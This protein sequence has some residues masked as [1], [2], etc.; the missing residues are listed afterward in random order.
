MPCKH[1][2]DMG[3]ILRYLLT[4]V[5]LSISH[6]G[7]TIQK[8][9]KSKLLQEIQRR[10]APNPPTN[11]DMVCSFSTCCSNLYLPLLASHI[12]F[13][14]KFAN[15]DGPENHLVF[16]KTIS[17]TIKDAET[18]KRSNQ[19]GMAYQITEPEQKRPSNW[20]Q[21]LRGDQF[22]EALVTFLV[23]IWGTTIPPES[24]V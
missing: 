1:E 24:W 21:E 2:F 4:P 16:D 20:H 18:N 3:Q 22:K 14:D 5:P 23:I 10:V 15:E 19:R 6:V 17:P 11:V 8:T 13:W 9:P 12:I 7:V